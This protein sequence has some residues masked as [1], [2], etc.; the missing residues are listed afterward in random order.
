MRYLGFVLLIIAV[1]IPA[2]IIGLAVRSE[3]THARVNLGD[4]ASSML[5]HWASGPTG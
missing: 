5:Q 4:L 1:L 3:A 2:T